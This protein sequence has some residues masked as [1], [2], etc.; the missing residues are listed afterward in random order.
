MR[1]L[2][3]NVCEQT[4]GKA[5]GCDFDRIVAGTSNYLKARF[6]FD[7]TW[8][9]CR[10]AAIFSFLDEEYPAPIINNACMIPSEALAYG[11]FDVQV[12]G[13]KENGFRIITNKER[14]LQ[15]RT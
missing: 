14:V 3:F 12:V 7:E 6:E 15:E 9:G 2:R 8:S 1:E 13:Q 11:Y 5:A 4:I 10:K